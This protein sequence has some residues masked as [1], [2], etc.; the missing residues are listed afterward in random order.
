MYVRLYVQLMFIH[1]RLIH[2]QSNEMRFN[3]QELATLATQPSNKFEKEGVLYV[4]ERQD[5]F[6]RRTEGKHFNYQCY[7]VFIHLTKIEIKFSLCD[8]IFL[9]RRKL[10]SNAISDYNCNQKKNHSPKNVLTSIRIYMFSVIQ[11]VFL[12]HSFVKCLLPLLQ[13]I[14]KFH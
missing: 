7:E 3:K 12:L 11:I 8:K 4:T 9:C 10:L 2:L 1:W 14:F 6:F 5:G 13:F